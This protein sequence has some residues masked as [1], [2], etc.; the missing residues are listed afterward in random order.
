[1]A[2]NLRL[3]GMNPLYPDN[4][5]KSVVWMVRHLFMIFTTSV[6][7]QTVDI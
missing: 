4:L 5:Y 3:R 2:D 6:G 7:N 1:M